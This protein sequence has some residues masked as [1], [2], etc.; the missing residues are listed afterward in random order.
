MEGAGVRCADMP[1]NLVFVFCCFLQISAFAREA[2]HIHFK[3]Q[4][5]NESPAKRHPTGDLRFNSGFRDLWFFFTWLHSIHSCSTQWNMWINIKEPCWFIQIFL[6]PPDDESYL[7]LLCGC[8]PFCHEIQ[9]WKFKSPWR[10]TVLSLQTHKATHTAKDWQICF[11]T[12]Q[13]SSALPWWWPH[14]FAW[15]CTKT[16][17]VPL[18]SAHHRCKPANQGES[19]RVNGRIWKWKQE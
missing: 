12:H 10:I 18:L 3:P 2:V 1:F 8:W 17:T 15:L 9:Y 16:L 7:N 11:C 6:R 13:E 14:I 4:V 5:K 19:L